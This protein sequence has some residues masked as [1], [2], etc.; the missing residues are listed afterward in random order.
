MSDAMIEGFRLSPQQQ[1]VWALQ[2]LDSAQPYRTQGTIV[3]EGSLDIARLQAS[4]LQVV[5]RYEILRTTFHYLQ[6]MA[7]PLQV[8]TELSE[9]A[10]PSYDLSE[11][12]LTDLQ[13]QLAQQAFDFAA[14]PLLHAW[15]GREH[16]LK[17]Y[18]LLSVPTLCADNLSLVNLTSELAAIYAAEPTT[19]E[20]MQYIDIA[21]WQHELLEAE[22]TAAG[23]SYWQQQTWHDAITVR[24]AFVANQAAA[25]TFQ[26]Q[27]LPIP[28]TEQ[29]I[30]LL[31]QASQ[32]LAVPASALALAAWRTL[33]WRLSD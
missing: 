7:L 17:H 20:P 23:R 12:S 3:I 10:L 1:H 33:L 19:D 21:E 26:P 28:L 30:E 18:L 2:Q 22:E 32:T 31:N 6:G 29:L 11:H 25:Q 13:S 5:Q 15:L 9:L 14:G 8:V 4:L 24:P 16:A 27:Q